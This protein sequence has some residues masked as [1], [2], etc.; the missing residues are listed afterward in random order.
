MSFNASKFQLLRLGQNEDLKINTIS[1]SN[2]MQEIL[3]PVEVVK[4]LGVQMDANAD[5]NI[6]REMAVLKTKRKAGWVLRTFACR[7]QAF[8]T[9]LWKTLVQPQQDYCSQLWSP[10][11][12]PGPLREQEEP[13]KAFSKKIKGCFTLNYWERLKKLG[14]SSNQRRNERYKLIYIWKVISG[15]V[16]NF[17]I[18]FAPTN[19]RL[20]RML[21]VPR[22]QGLLMRHRTLKEGSLAVEGPKLFNAMPRYLRDYMGSKDGF[23][24]VT[25]KFLSLLPDQPNGYRG[26][27]PQCV[28]QLCRPSNSVKDWT[29]SLSL[30][31]WVPMETG[32]R[33]L[34]D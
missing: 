9:T 3:E 25:D 13:L 29:H 21:Q 28:D 8:M 33:G 5:F 4:D 11:D 19:P 1:F 7:D 18:T 17:G 12:L 23:K 22:Y 32:G 20:G 27:I 2:G 34:L 15:L 31:D 30:R 6:Q 24:S 16:P 26:M 10:V 14:L